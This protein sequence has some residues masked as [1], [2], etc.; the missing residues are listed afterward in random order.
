[1]DIWRPVVGHAL[2]EVSTLGRVRSWRKKG[3]KG[4]KR[5]DKPLVIRQRF[6]KYGRLT[7]RFCI[8]CV[9]TI[10]H[11]HQLV[12]EAFVG[13]RKEG[14][15]TRHLDGNPVNNRL[16]NLKWGTHTE[17]MADAVRH[18]TVPRGEAHCKTTL[19]ESQARKILASKETGEVLAE[20]YGVSGSTVCRI[21]TGRRWKHLQPTTST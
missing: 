12:L 10:R 20:R 11:V 16:E 4:G 5:S 3:C 7:V 17:N 18:G 21:R 8:F 14:M 9:T 13:P 15:E 2:Y 6:D 19:T 1:M